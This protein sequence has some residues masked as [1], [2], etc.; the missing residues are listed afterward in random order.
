V[1]ITAAVMT[2]TTAAVMTATTA[3]VM[4]A[5]TA[6]IAAEPH[7]LGDSSGSTPVSRVTAAEWNVT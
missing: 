4:T 2:A 6:A 5:T 1:A 7:L 3:A